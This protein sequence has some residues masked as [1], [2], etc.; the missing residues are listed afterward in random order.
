MLEDEDPFLHGGTPLKNSPERPR[1][2]TAQ[3]HRAEAIKLLKEHDR[4]SNIWATLGIA[5]AQVH[6]TL[7]LSAPSGPP[8]G[9]L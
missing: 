5:K 3:E 6:A 7:A 2:M 1:E 9:A 8:F 4:Q